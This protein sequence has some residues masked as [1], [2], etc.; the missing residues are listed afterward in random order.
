MHRQL[1]VEQ[2]ELRDVPAAAFQSLPVFPFSDLAVTDHIRAIVARGERLGRHPGVF[3]KFGDSNSSTGG[4]LPPNYL[5]PLGMPAYNPFQSGLAAT[6]PELLDTWS[7]Y[8]GLA[9]VGV[10][11]LVR[12][13]PGAF[14]GW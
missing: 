14:P 2:L 6:H 13:G 4:L 1:Q 7:V 11:S 10:D 12:E 3:V 8:R 9:G 5:T